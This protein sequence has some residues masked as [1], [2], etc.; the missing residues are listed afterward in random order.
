L[1]IAVSHAINT[2][3]S[4]GRVRNVYW[5]EGRMRTWPIIIL[6][7]GAVSLCSLGGW[8][9]NNACINGKCYT[10]EGSLS[11]TGQSCTCNGVPIAGTPEVPSAQY[12][13]NDN[14]KPVGPVTLAEIRAK[15]AAGTIKPDTLVWKVG[16]PNWVAAKDQGDIAPLLASGQKPAPSP[17]LVPQLGRCGE[18]SSVAFSPDGHLLALGSDDGKVKLWDPASAPAPDARRGAN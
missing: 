6:A 12:Y 4:D 5:E 1:P 9:A 13:Y 14:G 18:V 2:K 16:M 8:A 11:C 10:C 15:I 17:V 3:S 7:T